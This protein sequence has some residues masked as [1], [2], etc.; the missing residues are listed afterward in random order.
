[1]TIKAVY[2][3][4][5]SDLNESGDW[6]MNKVSSIWTGI[7]SQSIYKLELNKRLRKWGESITLVLTYIEFFLIYELVH[8][9]RALGA[10]CPS[11][12]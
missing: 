11:S 7:D 6:K 1:M 4:S 2:V 8:N 5:T 3:I 12:D 9:A 10:H